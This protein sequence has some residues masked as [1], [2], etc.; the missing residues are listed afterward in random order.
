M[1]KTFFPS[2]MIV[3]LITASSALFI[4]VRHNKQ[5]KREKEVL[6]LKNDS[7]HIEQ[8]QIRKELTTVKKYLDST[9]SVKSKYS[10]K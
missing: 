9:L 6:L 3:L 7:L 1:L 4:T 8:I 2:V 5:L 10:F